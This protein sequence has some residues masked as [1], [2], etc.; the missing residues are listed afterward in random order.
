MSRDTR[1][2][3]VIGSH[4]ACIDSYCSG[5]LSVISLQVS[6][7]YKVKSFHSK[8]Q[9]YLWMMHAGTV[10]QVPAD[11][12]H[13]CP[14]SASFHYTSHLTLPGLL[15]STPIDDSTPFMFSQ[16]LLLW[17][18]SS[19]MLYPPHDLC[20]SRL[21]TV[22]VPVHK[23][24][25]PYSHLLQ[26]LDLWSCQSCMCFACVLTALTISTVLQVATCWLSVVS[27]GLCALV[28]T[29]K[30][31]IARVM[32]SRAIHYHCCVG[33]VPTQVGGWRNCGRGGRARRYSGW[34]QTMR[35]RAFLIPVGTK[36]S[37]TLWDCNLKHS[38]RN[39][40]PGEGT[41]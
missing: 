15:L 17:Q 26:P 41:R 10:P 34:T 14:A 9:F 20:Y 22:N 37:H 36:L 40:K 28:S 24:P 1:W 27:Q 2:I 3:L 13:H 18:S 35:L 30:V 31:H 6:V 12:P 38:H 11:N 21:V 39:N 7:E 19:V 5:T 33:R 4:W 23:W 32:R 16:E 29:W 25:S 8:H